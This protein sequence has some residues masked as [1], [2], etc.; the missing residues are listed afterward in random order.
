MMGQLWENGGTMVGQWRDNGGTM[1]GQWW[2]N[3]E[4]GIFEDI[5]REKQLNIYLNV[6]VRR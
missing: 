6:A 2:D 1:A 5:Y 3:G 4:G